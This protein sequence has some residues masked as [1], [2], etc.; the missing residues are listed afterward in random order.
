MLSQIDMTP[1]SVKDTHTPRCILAVAVWQTERTAVK[2]VI[3]YRVRGTRSAAVGAGQCMWAGG[4]R[5][6]LPLPISQAVLTSKIYRRSNRPLISMPYRAG[7]QRRQVPKFGH[8]HKIYRRKFFFSGSNT[9]NRVRVYYSAPYSHT[10]G[11]SSYV[12]CLVTWCQACVTAAA[13]T[14]SQTNSAR[15]KCTET[16][17]LVRADPL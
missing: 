9:Q 14:P 8:P 5:K 7:T 6:G 1:R 11:Y 12:S 16:L 2:I 4:R 10:D 3:P 17:F 15:S 13:H